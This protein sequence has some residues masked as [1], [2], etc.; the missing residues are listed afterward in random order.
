MRHF[1]NLNPVQRA[2]NDLLA[3]SSKIYKNHCLSGE[4]ITK[5]GNMRID[6]AIEKRNKKLLKRQALINKTQRV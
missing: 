4:G 3:K 1:T 2:V 6:K 5:E